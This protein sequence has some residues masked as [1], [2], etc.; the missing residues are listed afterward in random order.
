M[1]SQ[2]AHT[3]LE[4]PPN[5]KVDPGFQRDVNDSLRQ[6]ARQ[7]DSISTGSGAKTTTTTGATTSTTAATGG[8]YSIE[9]QGYLAIET[10]A[11]PPLIVDTTQ[12][13]RDVTAYVNEAPEGGAVTM[14]LMQGSSLWCSLKIEAGKV[15]SATTDG[16]ALAQLKEGSRLS[17]NITAVPGGGSAAPGRDLTVTIRV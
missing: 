16:S 10:N 14:D 12:S 15:A 11:A 9:V 4:L 1:P 13:V 2:N 5:D 6:I 7:L 3:W 17:L 8:Q